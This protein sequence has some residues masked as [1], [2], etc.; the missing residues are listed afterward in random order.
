MTL[1]RAIATLLAL[2]YGVL[3]VSELLL[4]LHILPVLIREPSLMAGFL[5]I[6][7]TTVGGL[8]CVIAYQVIRHHTEG[9][10]QALS[11]LLGLTAWFLSGQAIK[12]FP[13]YRHDTSRFLADGVSVLLPI[14]L[15]YVAYKLAF[16]YFRKK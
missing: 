1:K 13:L 11:A 5:A 10:L 7:S 12:R 3:G 8:L 15:G 2:V 14:L 4:G 6:A 16:G 9:A